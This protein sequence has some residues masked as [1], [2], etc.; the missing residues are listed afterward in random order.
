MKKEIRTINFNYTF[1]TVH[2]G[3]NYTL[4]NEHWINGGEFAEVVTKSVLGYEAK[5]DANTRYDEASDIEEINASVKSS[6]FTLVN[7]KLAET[8]EET[9]TKYFETVHSNI[10]IYTV[11]MENEATL[12]YMNKEEFNEFL[13]TFCFFN[14]RFN[15]RCRATSGK[16][17]AWFE[18]KLD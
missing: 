5:K 6:R 13:H 16:M 14:E 12:Y 1:N 9:I 18:N 4:D 11:V 2:K 17:I 15:V 7:M 8:F 10:W 3:A